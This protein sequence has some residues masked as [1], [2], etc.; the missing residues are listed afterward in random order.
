M[1]LAQFFHY[2]QHLNL[3]L[4][5]QV[6]KHTKIQQLLIGFVRIAVKVWIVLWKAFLVILKVLFNGVV[7]FFSFFLH[8]NWA[9]FKEVFARA[10]EKRLHGLSSEMAFHA[11][12]ALFPGLLA[13]F[14]AI[15]MFESLQSTLYQMARLLAEFVPNEVRV[16][17][18]NLLQQIF[19]DQ[20]GGIFSLSF[21]VSL[22]IFS[23]VLS[24]AMAALDQIHRIPSSQARPFWKAKL[25][26]LG[27]AIGTLVLLIM[28]S[29]FVLISDQ[30][31]HMLAARSCLL[32]T[33]P[34]CPFDQF[35][36]CLVKDPIRSCQLKLEMLAVWKQWKWPITLGV[37]S[38]AF[39][40]VYRFGPSHWQKGTPIMPGAVIAAGLWA[41]ISSMFGL[42][43]S[44]FSNY[45]LTYGTIG[46]F[47]ILLLWLYLSSLAMLIGAQLNVTVGKKMQFHKRSRTIVKYPNLLR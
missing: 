18:S 21:I 47:V 27:L 29:A 43:V 9:T 45:N 17:I 32:E 4:L 33:I 38:T 28:A 6:A 5:R 20:H 3:K 35:W 42:Y 25:V 2:L 30:I 26:S 34:N 8:L 15:G 13:V 16:I 44:H 40:F 1:L 39:A 22:W 36:N 31:V 37:V 19:K 7:R 14:S 10:A 24:A 12:L 41:L 11:T 46:T 23:G